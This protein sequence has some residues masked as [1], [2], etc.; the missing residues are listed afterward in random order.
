MALKD[1]LCTRG[2]PTTCSSRILEGWVPPYD[3][4]VV[5]RLSA[6]GAV[7][8]GKSN[9]DEF[10]MGS[11]TEHSAFG[12]TRN[13]H[14]LEP[15]AGRFLGWERRR[16]G[17][18]FR[19]SGPGQ[20]YR[21]VRSAS[22][23]P[24]AAWLGPSPRTAWSLV[25]GWSLLPVRSTRSAR[26]PRTWPTPPCSW[27]AS[28]GTTTLDSTSLPGDHVPASANLGR[29][30]EGLRV[31]VIAE[32]AAADGIGADVAARVNEAADALA[33][34]GA[35]VEEISVPAVRYGLSA[36]YMIAPAEASSNLARYDGVRYGLR[37]PGS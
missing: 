14:D 23:P 8:V 13:P 25:T 33:G 3:A 19:P 22:P 9:M 2:V 29:G 36:Y 12:P 20:R 30:V 7:F 1:L 21:G 27:T 10:A 24:S 35:K 6:A 34:A 26:S 15:G 32:L 37:V 5:T 28:L 18:R 31:G 16:R 4:T 11:S 17:R